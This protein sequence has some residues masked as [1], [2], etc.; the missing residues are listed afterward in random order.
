MPHRSRFGSLSMDD[1]TFIV[2]AGM[3]GLLLMQMFT[4]DVEFLGTG[5][6]V[7]LVKRL[8]APSNATGTAT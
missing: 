2:S 1:G 3:R 7:R 4:D 5:N 6:E 8:A